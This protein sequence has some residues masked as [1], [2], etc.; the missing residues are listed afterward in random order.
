M[1]RSSSIRSRSLHDGRVCS[2][3]R[4]AGVPAYDP[5]HCMMEVDT[6]ISTDFDVPPHTY[7]AYVTDPIGRIIARNRDPIEGNSFNTTVP[8]VITLALNR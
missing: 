5:V 7:F 8:G 2:I 3:E 1:C 6:S 4:C